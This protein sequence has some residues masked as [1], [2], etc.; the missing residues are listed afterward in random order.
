MRLL[1]LQETVFIIYDCY[2]DSSRPLFSTRPPVCANHKPDLCL[3]FYK[4]N[5]SK[6]VA[7]KLGHAY[8]SGE[9]FCFLCS[10]LVRCY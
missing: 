9:C 3:C 8:P 10:M 7:C 5:G 1:Q 6:C 4:C 2:K